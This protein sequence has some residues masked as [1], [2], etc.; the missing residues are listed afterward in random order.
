MNVVDYRTELNNFLQVNGGSHR[1]KWQTSSQGPD[2]DLLWTAVCCSMFFLR[3]APPSTHP[4]PTV[5]G[6]EYDRASSSTLGDA[7]ERAAH[8][9]HRALVFQEF[10]RCAGMVA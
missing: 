10:R 5:D 2:H 7:K 1:L 4:K 8:A 6:I 9:T 3:T